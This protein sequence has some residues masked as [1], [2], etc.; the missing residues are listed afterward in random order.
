MDE[1]PVRPRAKPHEIGQDLS[2][3]SIDE[4]K[5]RI[6]VLRAEVERLE[7]AIRAKEATKT[8][9]DTFFRR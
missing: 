4:L 3:L 7:A 9:A 6:G 8:A 2:V 5:E 1:E